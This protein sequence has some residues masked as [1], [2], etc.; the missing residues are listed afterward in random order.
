METNGFRA[1]IRAP[2][3]TFPGI[4]RKTTPQIA[5]HRPFTT[6]PMAEPAEGSYAVIVSESAPRPLAGTGVQG[7]KATGVNPP[8][9][10]AALSRLRYRQPPGPPRPCARQ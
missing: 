10:G 2:V 9:E 1:P 4:E 8:P 7:K 3:G 6:H 5:L